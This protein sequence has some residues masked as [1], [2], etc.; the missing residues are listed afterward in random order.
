ML[1]PLPRRTILPR[2]K[3]RPMKGLF[4]IVRLGPG[5]M[6]PAWL[7]DTPFL[8]ITRTE[9]ELSIICDQRQVPLSVAAER[10]WRGLKV[11]GPIDLSTPGVLASLASPLGDAG[12]PI[13]AL[14]TF[15][16]DYLL[17]RADRFEE[18]CRVL[19]AS[20]HIVT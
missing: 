4:A 15:D 11:E 6:V 2:M 5:E 7:G 19:A 8:S 10:E 14:S 20:G 1:R 9:E 12:V 18:A 17:V 3:L 13:F 16:T